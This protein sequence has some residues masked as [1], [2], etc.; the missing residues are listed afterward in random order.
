MVRRRHSDAELLRRARGGDEKAWAGLVERY[1]RLVYAIPLRVG[2]STDSSV[3]IFH[4]VFRQLLENLGKVHDTDTLV[5]WLLHTTTNE[6]R[7]LRGGI[8]VSPRVDALSTI[9]Q[10]PV[11]EDTLEHWLRQQTIR[12]ATAQLTERCQRLLEAV[13]YTENPPSHPELARRL[14][15]PQGRVSAEQ[16]RC[17][18]A[19]LDVLEA[20]DFE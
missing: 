8:V 19:L 18:E 5:N 12:E 7:R 6:A 20:W 11:S 10:A 13:L 17:F 2:L 16:A 4:S 1:S 15:V 14:N 9:G 3:N